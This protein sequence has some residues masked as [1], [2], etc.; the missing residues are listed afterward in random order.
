MKNKKIIP[1]LIVV[2]ALLIV[3]NPSHEKHKLKVSD[4]INEFVENSS[5]KMQLL[6][7]STNPTFSND[8]AEKFVTRK[9]YFL[10]SLSKFSL[11]NNIKTIGVGIMGFVYVP[12]RETIINF[13]KAKIEESIPI[14]E[15]EDKFKKT[16]ESILDL[17]K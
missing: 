16:K 17:L 15:D 7:K 11:G 9:N 10:F 1:I 2:I 8:I 4:T 14:K 12:D 13:A 6:I 3:T 5:L